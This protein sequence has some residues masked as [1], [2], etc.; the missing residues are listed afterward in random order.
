M[1]KMVR[2]Q[3]WSWANSGRCP[4]FE[5]TMASPWRIEQL[6]CELAKYAANVHGTRM[7]TADRTNGFRTVPSKGWKVANGRLP[8]RAAR[9]SESE[10]CI[11]LAKSS[12]ICSAERTVSWWS[13]TTGLS[14]GTGVVFRGYCFS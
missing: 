4:R 10:N 3:P 12:A 6:L 8:L 7:N 11:A 13:V 9:R 1:Y 5:K 2:N 14:A